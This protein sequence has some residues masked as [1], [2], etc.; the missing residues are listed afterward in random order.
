MNGEY[1]SIFLTNGSGRPKNLQF[2]SGTLT[3]TKTK[4][5][6]DLRF[7]AQHSQAF[8][9]LIAEKINRRIFGEGG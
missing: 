1:G 9:E 2:G 3:I 4:A 6:A 7:P 8:N 5:L